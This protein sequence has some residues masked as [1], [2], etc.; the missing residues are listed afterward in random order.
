MRSIKIYRKNSRIWEIPIANIPVPSEPKVQFDD[1]ATLQKKSLEKGL[2]IRNYKEK[3]L[4]I[5]LTMDIIKMNM[6]QLQNLCKKLNIKVPSG[7][8]RKLQMKLYEYYVS[9]A[10]SILTNNKMLYMWEPGD[11]LS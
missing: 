4:R 7:P 5:G 10:D 9:N 3:R 1:L 11:I 6:N 8:K 2:P